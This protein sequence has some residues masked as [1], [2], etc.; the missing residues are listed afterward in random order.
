[1]GEQTGSE[2]VTL[3]VGQMPNHTHPVNAVAGGG[4]VASPQGTLPAIESTG[5]SLNYSNGSPNVVMSSAMNTTAGGSQPFPVL[6]PL[7][8]VNFIIALQGIFPS[9]N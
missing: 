4:N 8:C 6:Q 7:L 9:R 2:N 5:T 3:S 1:M